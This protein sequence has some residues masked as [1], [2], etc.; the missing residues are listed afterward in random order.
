MLGS[1][2]AGNTGTA[3]STGQPAVGPIPTVRSATDL[4]GPLDSYMLTN[5][6]QWKIS[7]GNRISDWKCIRNKGFDIPVKSIPIAEVS[8]DDSF[9]YLKFLDAAT[10]SQYGYHLPPAVPHPGTEVVHPLF[11][12]QLAARQAW[13]SDCQSIVTQ[14]RS[15][16]FQLPV[17]PKGGV[18]LSMA[19]A[20]V[21]SRYLAVAARWSTCMSKSGYTFKTP[22][23]AM[24][25][26]PWGL[27][28][29]SGQ[30]R[31]PVT[32]VESGTA[33]ADARCR[34]ETNFQ[35]WWVALVNAYEN[36]FISANEGKLL[37]SK[38]IAQSE[39]DAAMKA[40][41]S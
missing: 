39:L 24:N 1:A 12:N 15:N 23:D 9:G 38:K 10:A 26:K 21:D 40:A 37:E 41:V 19:K 3:G 4:H 11:S 27:T 36:R 28:D 7:I 34:Q 14:T 16:Q 31:G 2:C 13:M 35:G 5:D 29:P 8:N 25:A 6:D 18:Q 32:A 22:L 30:S 17:D 20:Q 33:G